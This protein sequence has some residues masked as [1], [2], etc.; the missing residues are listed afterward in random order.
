MRGPL[1][2]SV[3]G[4][5]VAPAPGIKHLGCVRVFRAP[6]SGFVVMRSDAAAVRGIGRV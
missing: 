4:E 6:S 2:G 5:R 3:C 1:K